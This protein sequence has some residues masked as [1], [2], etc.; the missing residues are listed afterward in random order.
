VGWKE[1]VGDW[2][3]GDQ[4]REQEGLPKSDGD[5]KMPDDV[6]MSDTSS[7]SE[8][9]SVNPESVQEEQWPAVC[10][11]PPRYISSGIAVFGIFLLFAALYI[12]AMV[13][14]LFVASRFSLFGEMF[15]GWYF[16]IGL[17]FFL[18]FPG[19]FAGYIC[20]IGLFIIALF[21]RERND[22][23]TVLG[24]YVCALLVNIGGYSF[25][26]Y[27]MTEFMRM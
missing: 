26:A 21:M 17:F 3:M 11:L 4:S 15:L 8:K 5:D 14:A 18:G 2:I 16:P 1:T 19:L 22:L 25:L 20:Y 10:P 27:V 13:A 9:E 24:I 6:S 23:L 7:I 12:L